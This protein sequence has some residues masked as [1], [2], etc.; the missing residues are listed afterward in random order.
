MSSFSDSKDGPRL[1]SQ[2]RQEKPKIAQVAR[3]GRKG[4]LGIERPLYH[5]LNWGKVM[6]IVDSSSIPTV[7]TARILFDNQTMTSALNAANV[8]ILTINK[9][10]WSGF[11]QLVLACDDGIDDSLCWVPAEYF[12]RCDVQHLAAFVLRPKEPKAKKKRREKKKK[13]RKKKKE[14]KRGSPTLTR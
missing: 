8:G 9:P 12:R 13:K 10:E 1:S 3:H 6:E 4:T 14:E 5:M 7:F 11:P 2:S